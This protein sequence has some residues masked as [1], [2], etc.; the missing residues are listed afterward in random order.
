MQRLAIQKEDAHLGVVQVDIAQ[1]SAIPLSIIQSSPSQIRSRPGNTSQALNLK[2]IYFEGPIEKDH[3]KIIKSVESIKE[4]E[5]TKEDPPD[6]ILE[7]LTWQDKLVL[8]AAG[9]LVVS[10]ELKTLLPAED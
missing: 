7:F 8:G 6:E 5:K 10:S 9:Q 2:S 1:I 4:Y 3:K